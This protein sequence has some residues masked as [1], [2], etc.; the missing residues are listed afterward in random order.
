MDRRVGRG[1]RRA[2]LP[3]IC[4]L[5][6]FC[7]I[8]LRRSNLLHTLELCF[9]GPSAGRPRVHAAL[10]RWDCGKSQ[11]LK[12]YLQELQR[13][14]YGGH[15]CS[16]VSARAHFQRGWV[17]QWYLE[18]LPKCGWVWMQMNHSLM[19]G[20]LRELEQ[21][22]TISCH[23]LRGTGPHYSHP[24]QAHANSLKWPKSVCNCRAHK[25]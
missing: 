20:R 8:S 3:L 10:L 18:I 24:F 22:I 7:L 25:T 6:F 14:H 5:L 13:L 12:R 11:S 17:S 4:W 21:I 16:L 23:S 15:S 1:P 9:S 2:S 19:L